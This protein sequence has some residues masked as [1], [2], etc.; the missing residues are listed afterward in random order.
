MFSLIF[1]PL[2]NTNIFLLSRFKS[3]FNGLGFSEDPHRR[4]SNEHYR[5]EKIPK[6]YASLF[7][8]FF[9]LLNPQVAK[10]VKTCYNKNHDARPRTT[11]AAHTDKSTTNVGEKRHRLKGN[12]VSQRAKL[13]S[14]SPLSNLHL[15]YS[16]AHSRCI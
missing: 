16:M 3:V 13:Y 1:F 6:E 5:C 15:H 9:F 2:N 14:A 4:S 11:P 10:K 7:P 8:S 12:G